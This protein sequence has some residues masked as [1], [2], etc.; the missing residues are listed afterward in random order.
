MLLL[1]LALVAVQ[2]ITPCPAQQNEN[3]A[4]TTSDRQYV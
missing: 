2:L 4:V 1:L 3:G